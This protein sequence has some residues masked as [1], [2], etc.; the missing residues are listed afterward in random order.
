MVEVSEFSKESF[1]NNGPST[2]TV[3]NFE[4]IGRSSEQNSVLTSD[5]RSGGQRFLRFIYESSQLLSGKTIQIS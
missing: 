2:I 3:L 4:S 1:I 5:P